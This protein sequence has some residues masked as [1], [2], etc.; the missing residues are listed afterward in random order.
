MKT[1]A[2]KEIFCKNEAILLI[3]LDKIENSYATGNFNRNLISKT[4]T[5]KGCETIARWKFSAIE[6]KT[7]SKYYCI[8]FSCAHSIYE[9]SYRNASIH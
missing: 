3:F 4:N 1:L 7:D 9:N 2:E 5:Y 8:T 6:A